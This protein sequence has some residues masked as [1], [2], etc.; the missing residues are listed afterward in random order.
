MQ[1]A[2]GNPYTRGDYFHLYINGQYWG[3]FQTEERPEANFARDYFGGSSDDYDV[4]K[5]T[6][7]SGGYQNEATD[8]NLEAYERL[9]NL[10]YQRNGLSDANHDDFMRAQ[11]LNPDGSVNPDYERLLDIDNLIDYMLITYYTSDADGPGSQFTRPRVNNYFAIYNREDPDGFKFFEHD[12]EHSLDTGNAAGAN[13]N[14]VEPFTEGGSQFRYFNPH[15]MHEQLASSN[16][17]YRTQFMDRVTEQ[18]FNDGV[19]TAEN[20]LSMIQSRASEIDQAIIAE[21]ARWGDAREASPFT[22]D[23]WVQ[24]VGRIEEFIEG[25]RPVLLDQL[26]NVDWYPD[27]NPPEFLVNSSPQHGGGVDTNDEIAI[28]TSTTFSFDQ[29]LVS[30]GSVWK[31]LDNGS[32][33]G[34]AW[35]ATSFNDASWDAG[36]AELGYGDGNEA[37]EVS[38]GSN[39]NDKHVT[40]YY[41]KS[42]DV[43]DPQSVDGLKIQLR[44]D[45]GAVV[46]LNGTEVARSNL[47]SG[48]I[49]FDTSA[50]SVVGGSDETTYFEFEIDAELLNQ[51]NNV[52]AVEVHQIVGNGGTVTS[53]DTSFDL[54]LLGGSI[55]LSNSKQIYYTTDGSDPRLSGGAINPDAILFDPADGFTLSGDSQV[56]ARTRDGDEWGTALTANFE[57][58]VAVDDMP[59]AIADTIN[60]TE[61]TLASA[62]VGNNDSLSSDGGNVFALVANASNGVA[63]VAANGAV[64]YSPNANFNGSDSFQYRLTDADGDA[65]VATV[66]VNVASVND[67]PVVVN[68]SVSG[69]EDTQ[70]S[71]NVST[72]DTLSGDG[73][74]TFSL[75]TNPANGFVD[76]NSNG[77]F[78]YTPDA[79]FNGSD[80]FSYRLTDANGDARTATVNVSVAS[81]DDQP[82]VTNDSFSGT[83]DT[84][85][86]G[87]VGAN[88][89]LS[90]DGGNEFSLVASPSNGSVALNDN[91]QFAYTPAANFNGSDSFTYQLIDAD[92]DSRTGTVSLLVDSVDD[93]PLAFD[94]TFLAT[95][96]LSLSG[97]VLTNDVLSGDG[98]NVVAVATTTSNGTLSLAANGQFTYT[99][100]ANFSGSDSFTYSL[101]DAD[102]DVVTS[103][104]SITVAEAADVPV[105]SN[106]LFAATE[107]VVFSGNVGSNDS[108]SGDGGNVFV[109]SS[110]PADGGISLNTNGTFTYTPN[111]NFNGS[112]AFSYT[113]RDADGDT[114]TAT[115][116]INVA[117]VNDLPVAFDDSISTDE[118]NAVSGNVSENDVLSADGGNTYRVSVPPSDG[119]VTMNANGTFTYTPNIDFSGSDSFSYELTDI[120]GDVRSAVVSVSVA[121]VVSSIPGDLNEDGTL[122][123][124]DI[125]LLLAGLSENSSAIR[126]DVNE[127]DVVDQQDL[128]YMIETIFRTLPGDADLDGDVDFADFLIL[129]ANFGN[130]DTGWQEGNFNPD[131]ETSFTD[132]LLLSA[133]FG[134]VR[135]S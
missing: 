122:S 87:D 45:D 116:T 9:A 120:D 8:G 60:A 74:N 53:S 44:R 69:N 47:P 82:S 19:L 92:G 77:S 71:G 34:T 97:N 10:F 13:Y 68:D 2:L 11:G 61:D 75:V 28:A 39:S 132:F 102:G 130:S 3:L 95:E 127:D 107:D 86:N 84:V 125:D 21:S 134:W 131:D 67:L 72:N 38:F 123:A 98:G 124:E 93:L 32:N 83:E 128:D 31:F 17:E 73:G 54:A 99:P 16:T 25:R 111:A 30:R 91:G 94:D 1:G 121:D 27:E 76:F 23:D 6:G 20:A 63:T 96:D 105:A 58:A 51:G 110:G 57:V 40:T 112:D 42:F 66:T 88:D 104:V 100:T 135:D 118:N 126:L 64:T 85:L 48:T 52:L 117:S 106:D 4:V 119:Q 49:N 24:A 35:R 79:N 103:T 129:S 5:S 101:T 37:T 56:T 43:A 80:S 133:N 70:I 41:R 89:T 59:E 33:Q 109:L 14:L 90:G 46:Y 65:S 114:S 7:S 108:L 18:L 36:N 78:A 22:K 62:N 113:L 26:R 81:V 29:T 55:S 15:W 115:V 12:S 50:S